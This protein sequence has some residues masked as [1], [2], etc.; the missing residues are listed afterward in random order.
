MHAHPSDKPQ[1]FILL[2]LV[3]FASVGAVLFTP[4]L[5]EITSFFHVSVGQAQITITAYL[6][7]YALGQL[8]YGP[9]ANRFGRKITLYIGIS[10]AIVGSLLCAFSSPL[11]SFELLVIA[12]FLQALG[13][14][15]GLKISYTMI[16][17]VYNQKEATKIFSSVIIAFAIMPGVAVAIGGVLTQ[18]L[19]WESCFY[20]L[21]LFAAFVL[22]LSTKLPETAK[23]LDP[24]ALNISSII[25]GYKSKFK[26]K[27]LVI[28]GLMIGC[29]SAVIYIFAA[30]SPFIGIDLIG[31]T[32]AAFGA[33]NLIPLVGMLLGAFCSAQLAGRISLF[34]LLLLGVTA[35]LTATLTMLIPFSL[36]MLNAL[37]LF[38][39]MFLIYIAESLVFAN[40]S[41]FGL[42]HAKNKS[43]GSAILNFISLSVTVIA[44]LLSELIYPESAILLPVSL[45]V[46]FLI[47]FLLWNSLR[48]LDEKKI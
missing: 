27:H 15:V 24:N 14:C 26:N 23:T 44:V 2:L 28:S 6:L 37:S 8:P 45:V 1:L 31:L 13:A 32:P 30:K 20:F 43:N 33:Y 19:N 35:S 47:M 12:R 9:L 10:L 5:P 3:S 34:N 11:K 25:Q 46:C 42:A 4:A 16:A 41:S 29:G 39:P 18:L 21:A 36:G 17:D 48:K 38:L 7:G 40:I 22:W